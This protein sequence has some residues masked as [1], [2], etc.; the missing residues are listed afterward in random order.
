MNLFF[1][2]YLRLAM[3]KMIGLHG[4]KCGKNAI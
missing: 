2:G 3:G 1:A 4:Q